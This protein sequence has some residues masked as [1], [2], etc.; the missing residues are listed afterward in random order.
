MFLRININFYGLLAITTGWLLP[1]G[2]ATALDN[3]AVTEPRYFIAE[4]SIE[5]RKAYFARLKKNRA[6]TY[7]RDAI[8]CTSLKSLESQ[9]PINNF[10]SPASA[11]QDAKYC[12][13]L[14]SGQIVEAKECSPSFQACK[15]VEKD[16]SV[17]F[18]TDLYNVSP[19]L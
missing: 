12:T 13:K 8:T 18:W 4:E 9:S 11:E 17:E 14:I 5:T 10:R 7:A 2:S 6:I 16:T 19:E 1:N 15:F 3:T